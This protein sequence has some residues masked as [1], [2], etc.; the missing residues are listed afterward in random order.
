MTGGGKHHVTCS[1]HCAA[2]A[3]VLA[4]TTATAVSTAAGAA[5][6]AAATPPGASPAASPAGDASST[7]TDSA[8]AALHGSCCLHI[9][10][11]ACLAHAFIGG[12]ALRQD[13]KVPLLESGCAGTAR[14]I[15]SRQ[16]YHA[17]TRAWERHQLLCHAPS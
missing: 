11:D 14:N 15:G 16:L 3:G 1:V 9:S 17:R 7:T 13:V 5:V 12:Y 6:A 4:G 8:R 10:L 2:N